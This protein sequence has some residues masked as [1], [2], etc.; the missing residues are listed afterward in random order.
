MPTKRL[1][2]T[3]L[4]SFRKTDCLDRWATRAANTLLNGDDFNLSA[5]EHVV[6][7][8][9]RAFPHRC[10][11][12]SNILNICKGCWIWEKPLEME[13]IQEALK[14]LSRRGFLRKKNTTVGTY[15]KVK[16][17]IWEICFPNNVFELEANEQSLEEI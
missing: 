5:A 2:W 13:D 1:N 12:E 7:Q 17:A 4:E 11:C 14:I 3:N 16:V 15:N 6:V 9:F 10:L 8:C